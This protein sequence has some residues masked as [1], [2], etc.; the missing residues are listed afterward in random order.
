MATQ[1]ERWKQLAETLTIQVIA[2]FVVDL[3]GNNVMFTALLPQ[4]GSELGMV[5]DPDWSIIEPHAEALLRSGYGFSAIELDDLDI[6]DEMHQTL[7]DWGWS[8]ATLKPTW[9]R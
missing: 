3:N 4:F 5:V 9:Y 2:P 1:S 6:Q 7:Y 8:A